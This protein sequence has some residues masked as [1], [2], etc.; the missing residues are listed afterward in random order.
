MGP[1]IS[2]VDIAR[3]Y[4]GTWH[5]ILLPRQ[6]V[7]FHWICTPPLKTTVSE[8]TRREEICVAGV[9]NS[10][11]VG[12]RIDGG[13]IKI[14]FSG[15]FSIC[16]WFFLLFS[17][18]RLDF[19]QEQKKP[20]E[21]KEVAASA[22]G[23]KKATPQEGKKEDKEEKRDGEKGASG[24]GEKK[25]GEE[26]PP[27]PPPPPEEVV[28]KVY[29][30]CEGC[31]RKVRRSLK[32]FQGIEIDPRF[33]LRFILLEIDKRRIFF[34]FYFYFLLFGEGRGGG[35]DGGLPASQGGGEGAESSGGP[36]EGGGKSPEEES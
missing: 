1:E 13:G 28:M 4:T 12:R 23:E 16:D 7:C 24:N 19:C 9:T 6:M 30:H 32:G 11:T 25:E 27:P 3:V 2:N 35:G 8:R 21:G 20:G 17:V 14:A 10:S 29:M 34:F 36:D 15:L 22:E 33:L 18:K 5:V 31:A 26:A